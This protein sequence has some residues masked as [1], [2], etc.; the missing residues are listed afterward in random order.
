MAWVYIF[1]ASIFEI[2]WAVG[3]K[4]SNGFTNFYPSLFTI[5]TMILSYVFLSLGVKTLPIGTAYAVWT[6]IGAV[7]T[8]IYGIL[9]FDEPKDFLRL[10]FIFLIVV[11]IIGLRLTYKEN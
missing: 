11:G 1:I 9:F 7:G 2:S 5:I 3:L 8:A 4:Y 10:F 6:G